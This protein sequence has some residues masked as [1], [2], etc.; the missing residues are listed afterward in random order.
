MSK[1]RGKPGWPRSAPARPEIRDTALLRQARHLWAQR[2]WD[3]SL[4]AFEQALEQEPDSI[5]ALVD[6]ARAFGQRYDYERAEALIERLLKLA[7]Q[8]AQM[9]ALAGDTFRLINRYPQAVQCYE[10]ASELGYRQPETL[11]ELARLYERL[12]RL[13][14]ASELIQ[15]VLKIRTDWPPAQLTKAKL[16][17]RQKLDQQAEAT[18]RRLLAARL[19]DPDLA[20]EAWAELAQV[21]DRQGDYDGAMEAAVYSKQLMLPRETAERQTAGFVLGR[22]KKM[23]DGLTG[24]DLRRWL[25]QSRGLEH[26]AL[27][28]L[29]GFPRTGTTLLEQVLDAHPQVVSSEERDIMGFEVFPA[30]VNSVPERD[31]PRDVLDCV[32]YELLKK[33]QDRYFKYNQGWIG[34]PLNG[35]TL[36]DKN[37]GSTLLLPVFLRVFPQFKTLLALRDPRDVILSCFMLYLPLNP[38]SVNFLTLERAAHKYA[39]DMRGWL[40][41]RDAFPLPW[42]EVR[43]ED[44]VTNLA[45]QARRVLEFLD[46]P[47]DPAVLAFQDHGQTKPVLSPT[48]ADV[49]QPVHTRAIGRWRNYAEYLEPVLPILEP[50]VKAF[51]YEARF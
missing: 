16:E 45:A 9:H 40:K 17:R 31:S 12:H 37:P 23:F 42:L 14:E 39:L 18:L 6:A 36:L 24:E 21:L 48:Y 5:R 15:R 47:W 34:Q 28:L 27:A 22:F 13:D 41:M 4:A 10:R 7:G 25:E 32:S 33:E 46:L 43:Y 35:R 50:F 29:T 3:E 30:L 20:A 8:Q 51:G 2:R 1:R 44:T 38:L 49:T 19:E 11:L 26:S